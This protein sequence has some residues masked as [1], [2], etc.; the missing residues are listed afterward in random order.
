MDNEADLHRFFSESGAALTLAPDDTKASFISA[1]QSGGG[2][3]YIA[4]QGTED[5]GIECSGGLLSWTEFEDLLKPCGLL[6]LAS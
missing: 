2:L 6:V 3:L 1:L 5:G 4:A